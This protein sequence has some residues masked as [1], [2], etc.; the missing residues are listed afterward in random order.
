MAKVLVAYENPRAAKQFESYRSAVTAAVKRMGAEDPAEVVQKDEPYVASAFR[1]G[2]DPKMAAGIIFHKHTGAV[3]IAASPIGA[4]CPPPTEIAPAEPPVGGAFTKVVRDE[5]RFEVCRKRALDL[6]SL[7]TPRA[8]Y[9]LVAPEL[10]VETQEVFIAIGFDVNMVLL[11][12]DEIARGQV[13]HVAVAPGDILGPILINRCKAFVVA[14]NHPSGDA[15]PS[16][17]DTKLTQKLREAVRPFA[18]LVLLDHLVIG[19]GEFYSFT[20]KK[21]TK[22]GWQARGGL[23]KGRM[24]S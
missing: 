19:R 2:M 10:T 23:Q 14:H 24:K 1:A 11:S 18:G 7:T 9:S 21:L 20:E 8:I 15:H 6:G 22:D 16:N 3:V 5:A 13:D 17:D 4:A 12:Y